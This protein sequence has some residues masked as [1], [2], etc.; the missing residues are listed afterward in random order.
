MYELL[1][2]SWVNASRYRNDQGFSVQNSNR[3]GNNPR[4]DKWD[5]VKLR[6]LYTAMETV[7]R[8]T[9]HSNHLYEETAYRG[10]EFFVHLKAGR[11]LISRMYKQLN[12]KSQIIHSINEL[13]L[14][15]VN[16]KR[17][18]CL[19]SFIIMEMQMKIALRSHSTS[20]RMAISRKMND[21]PVSE[22]ARN[23][24]HCQ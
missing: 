6:N 11:G 23:L 2:K 8:E 14:P 13:M 9:P 20:A 22:R 3:K 16:Q 7:N 10:Q 19:T 12:T 4:I 1:D 21:N 5:C 15:G 17:N 18:I 24:I